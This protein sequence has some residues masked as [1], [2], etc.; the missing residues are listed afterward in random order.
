MCARSERRFTS[1]PVAPAQARRFV[2]EELT[3][4]LRPG[5]AVADVLDQA[6]L[7]TSE[8][9]ANAVKASRQSFEVA[10]AVHHTWVQVGVM[11]QGP[12]WP[13]LQDPDPREPGGRGLRIVAAVA[14]AWGAEPVPAG[15]KR[16][17][18]RLPLPNGVAE[19][20]DCTQATAL[21]VG[22][23][24]GPSARA[25]MPANRAATRAGATPPHAPRSA[26]HPT[27]N[28]R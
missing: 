8:V 9:A 28:A 17:W 3:G 2:R 1:I 20:L 19:H 18:F 15:G 14:T 10:L 27:S 16:V 21:P 26:R 23:A 22:A 11:D 6:E 5:A 7:L 13:E 25:G 4:L 12:G 24:A